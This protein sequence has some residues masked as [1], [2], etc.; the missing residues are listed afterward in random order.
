MN[1]AEPLLEV[2]IKETERPARTDAAKNV[3]IVTNSAKI[4]RFVIDAFQSFYGT[5]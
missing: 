2:L 3:V 5:I 4:W 1:A